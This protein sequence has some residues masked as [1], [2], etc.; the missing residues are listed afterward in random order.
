MDMCVAE[1]IVIKFSFNW[2]LI[3]RHHLMK[4]FLFLFVSKSSIFQNGE[5][6]QA[7]AEV[8]YLIKLSY[9]LGKLFL[10]Q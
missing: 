6:T 4:R 1:L 2:I 3:F 7:D 8:S 10:R 9:Q 5:K